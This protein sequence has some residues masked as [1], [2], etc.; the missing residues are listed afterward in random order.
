M[1]G[2][3]LLSALAVIGLMLLKELLFEWVLRR[4]LKTTLLVVP[5]RDPDGLNREL[6]EVARGRAGKTLAVDYTEGKFDRNKYIE[7]GLCDEI[8][9]P[10]ELPEA[11]E[12]NLR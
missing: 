6:M 1:S 12:R 8:V 3:I 4:E 9:T 7:E 11:I 5:V 2:A 10:Q